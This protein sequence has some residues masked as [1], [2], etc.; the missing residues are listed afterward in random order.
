MAKREKIYMPIGSGGLLRYS[1]EGK[2][3]IK[4]KPKQLVFISVGIIIFELI[5]KFLFG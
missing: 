2:E 3:Y 5:L 1:E 4:I